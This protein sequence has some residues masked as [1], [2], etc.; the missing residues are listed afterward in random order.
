MVLQVEPG[1]IELPSIS[2]VRSNLLA[3]Y[4]AACAAST[5]A[6]PL[7][8]R[9][10]PSIRAVCRV[11]PYATEGEKLRPFAGKLGMSDFSLRPID[12]ALSATYVFAFDVALRAGMVGHHPLQ[13][14]RRLRNVETGRPQL[15]P[16]HRAH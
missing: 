11:V 3:A 13:F 5:R 16:S 12:F 2:S 7:V 9:V 6:R 4:G 1:R 8:S 10:S 14:N 15:A